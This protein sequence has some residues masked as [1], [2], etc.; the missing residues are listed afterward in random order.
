MLMVPSALTWTGAQPATFTHAGMPK[1]ITRSFCDRCR[2]RIVTRR[3]D[4]TALVLKV[5]T[6][7]DPSGLKPTAAICFD[8]A[9]PFHT[10][11]KGIPTY[12]GS[13]RRV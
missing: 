1:P 4:H 6:L 11:A 12:K 13:P 5:G 7:D 2:T 10:V 3:Q 8:E 9:Q